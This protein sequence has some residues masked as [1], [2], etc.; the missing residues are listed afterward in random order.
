MVKQF[1][2]CCTLLS[3]TA[4]AIDPYTGEEKV[5]NTAIGAGI[6]AATGAAIGA[7]ADG[8]SGAWKGA[9]AGTAAGAGIGYYMDRQEKI[10]RLKLRRSGVQ[11]QREG[12]N[13]RL[14]MPGDITF[15]TG[16]YTIQNQFYNVL[17]AVATVINE[18]NKTM[19][20]ISGHTDSTGGLALNQRLSEQRA[21][22]VARYLNAQGVAAN[23]MFAQGFGQNHPIASNNTKQ[24]R[25]ANRRVEI[26]L[27][28]GSA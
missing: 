21:N 18:F 13:I 16:Q 12:D 22:S 23:R 26:R 6:G 8:G 9:I 7:A 5:S 20:E 17:N 24:G 25:R 2:L 15:N 3:I 27:L 14:I 10:L 4:C 28:P 19:V 11:I 1:I